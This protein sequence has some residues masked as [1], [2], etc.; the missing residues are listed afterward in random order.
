MTGRT[1]F[2]FLSV[3]LSETIADKHCRDL[4]G[5]EK[6]KTKATLSCF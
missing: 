6:L 1:I 3:S 4:K 5:R 2:R